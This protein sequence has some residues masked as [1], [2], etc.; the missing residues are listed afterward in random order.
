MGLVLHSGTPPTAFTMSRKPVKLT[1]TKWSIRMPVFFSTVLIVQATPR[2][3]LFPSRVPRVNASLILKVVAE[4]I[5]PLPITQ[6]G[7]L[8]QESRGI[9]MTSAH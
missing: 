4:D 3:V 7:M 1:T 8:T 6:D 2:A 5:W 9:D